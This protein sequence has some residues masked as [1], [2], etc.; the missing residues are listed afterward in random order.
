[1]CACRWCEGE[2]RLTLENERQT[3]RD[4]SSGYL[5]NEAESLRPGAQSQLENSALWYKQKAKP[6]HKGQRQFH[7]FVVVAVLGL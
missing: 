4:C 7:I 1:M 2:R 5:E 3:D 6:K